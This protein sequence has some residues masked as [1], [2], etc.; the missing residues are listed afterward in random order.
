MYHRSL[1]LSA[2]TRAWVVSQFRFEEDGNWTTPAVFFT[3]VWRRGYV[4]RRF[5]LPTE[6]TH[7]ALSADPMASNW[8]V[9]KVAMQCTAAEVVLLEDPNGEWGT[10]HPR[11][12][13]TVK[14][15]NSVSFTNA[16]WSQYWLG[17]SKV[18]DAPPSPFPRH[19]RPSLRCVGA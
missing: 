3:D 1:L 2:H 11:W 19:F 12:A 17:E 8:G 10:N 15:R 6:P 9:W 4:S 18:C 5:T 14:G 13:N 16:S 7:V